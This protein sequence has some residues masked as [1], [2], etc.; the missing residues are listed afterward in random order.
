MTYLYND[1]IDFTDEMTE[2]FLAANSRLVAGVRGGVIRAEPLPARR[3]AVVI[4]GGS[5]H[6]PAF[7]GLVGSGLATGAAMGNLFASPSAQQILS[8]AR[9][10]E[11]GGGVLFA[12]GNYAGDVLNFDQAQA[13]LTSSGIPCESVAVTDDV[14]SAPQ[15]NRAQRRG[16]AGGLI[17]YKVAGAAADRGADLADVTRIARHANDRTR[18]IGVAFSGCTLPG[19]AKPLFTVAPG[20][21]AVGM[22]VHGEPGISEIPVPSA[23]ELAL[24]FVNTLLDEV[25]EGASYSGARVA[26]L[27][28]GLGSIKSEELFVVYRRVA[29][30]LR[31]LGIVVVDAEVGEFITS[32]E[33]AGA[34][35]TV[36]WLDDELEQLWLAPA[37]TPAFTRTARRALVAGAPRAGRVSAENSSTAAFEADAAAAADAASREAA[38]HVVD[39][40]RLARDAIA[41][42]AEQLGD[43]DSV[44][45]D[46]DHG[47]GMLRGVTAAAQ[48]AA[49]RQE[50]GAGAGSVLIAAGA[51]WA[52]RGGGTSGAIWGII[53]RALGQRLG[54][55]GTPD[56]GGVA[57]AVHVAQDEVAR[58]GKV[59]VGDKT[60]FDALV[61][62]AAM[63]ESGASAG[64]PLGVA[65][66]AAAGAA[67]SAA[68]ATADLSA[69]IGRARS[70]GDKSVGTRDPGAVSLALIVTAVQPI[71][72]KGVFHD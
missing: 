67:S 19:A 34:S 44:A 68:E 24:L 16:I 40:L 2:G 15:S 72:E 14:S 8:V 27:L 13:E 12:Y 38:L 64:E 11:S 25:P 71:F 39:A 1:P 65:W 61:P 6:Y 51:A 20:V 55:R 57:A 48:T 18:T 62:F 10:A 23:D 54:D 45:G 69:R 52:D 28:N 35:L 41:A 3:V 17:V 53:L 43:L 47:I 63:L 26:L 58:Y 21:M 49:H 59:Q 31:D 46:G 22:G 4:G 66:S 7:A 56:T 36:C 32:F 5:G 70:H 30:L 60:L 33:M 9:A 50:L 29:T 37:E 42:A